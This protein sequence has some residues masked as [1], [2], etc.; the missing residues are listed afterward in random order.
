MRLRALPPRRQPR[1]GTH[2][3]LRAPNPRRRRRPDMDVKPDRLAAQL[4]SGPLRPAWLVASPEPLLM[5][6][7]ADAIRAAARAQGYAEREVFEAEGNQREP[8][9]NALEASFR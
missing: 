6:E 1:P 5:L 7:A 8:D 3:P 2:H 9:W 4:A